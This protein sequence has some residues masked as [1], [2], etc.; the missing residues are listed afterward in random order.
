MTKPLLTVSFDDN[1]LA[2]CDKGSINIET[3]G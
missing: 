2:V 3:K 1:Y